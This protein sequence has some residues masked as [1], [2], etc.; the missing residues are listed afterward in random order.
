MIP[1][2]LSPTGKKFSYSLFRYLGLDITIICII[3]FFFLRLLSVPGAFFPPTSLGLG[4]SKN[5]WH[6][7]ASLSFNDDGL[8]LPQNSHR[9][10]YLGIREREEYILS[11]ASCSTDTHDMI[12][13]WTDHPIRPVVKGSTTNS[14]FSDIIIIIIVK[15]REKKKKKKIGNRLHPDA[16][17]SL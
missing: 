1:K 6:A 3:L 12:A 14:P 13:M 15:E 7:H 11:C 10:W 8:T 17:E 16:V 2:K 5:H 4:T 9:I